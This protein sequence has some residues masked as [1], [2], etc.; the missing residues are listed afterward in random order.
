MIDVKNKISFILVI[1]FPYLL[2]AQTTWQSEMVYFDDNDQLVYERDQDQNQIPDFSYAGYKN[3]ETR[4]PDVP[5]VNEI[6]PV[7]GDN[8]A[9][10]QDAL[11][12][13][14]LMPA[15]SN[16]IRGALLLKAGVYEVPGTIKL[17]F[18]GVVLR[19]EGDGDDP[20]NNTI[21]K[22]TGNSPAQRTIIVAGGGGTTKWADGVSG[23]VVN[24]TS[25]TVFVGDRTFEVASAANYNIGDNIIIVHPCTQNWLQSI[26]FGGTYSD[27]TGAEPGVDVPWAVNSHPLVFNRFIKNIDG[28]KITVGAPIFNHLIKNLA[29]SYIY[30]YTRFNIKTQ[31]GIEN[32]RVDIVTAGG[33]DEN[34]AWNA[35]DLYQIEDAWVRDCTM[36]HFGLSGIRTNTA[37]RITVE[38]CQALD[39][40]SAIEGGK[41]YNF[42][43][44][45]ASQQILFKNCHATNGR[46]HYVSNGTSWVSGC[47]FVDCTSSGAYTSSEGH[48]GWSMGLL[49]DNLIELDGPRPGLNARMLGLY[50]RGFY[51]TS[52]GWSTAHSVAWACDM[53]DG[54]LI[55]QQPPTAQNYAI[56]CLGKNITGQRPPA[57]FPD[58]S[59][60]IEGSNL[61]GL[62]P[63]S[64]YLAQLEDRLGP[65][66]S[67]EP[68]WIA[69]IPQSMI[70]HQ[71]YPNPFNPVTKISWQLA[72][73]SQ[74]ELSIYNVLGEKMAT[75]VD[76]YQPAGFYQLGWDAGNFASGIYYYKLSTGLGLVQTRKMLFVK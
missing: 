2:Q 38:N 24:I 15:D 10:I 19:G 34:H 57:P 58:E 72:V 14:G 45:T 29:Q 3:G 74:V 65:A 68:G 67:V 76:E 30:K 6:E 61:P 71:N 50:N 28:N 63:R 37:T 64:L 46:H 8:T 60:Y 43:V 33:G 31:I 32:L 51:G 70:L 66:V 54:D 5:T 20:A 11:E 13:I 9:H 18:D 53:N 1:L 25:D 39:P 36:L 7:E 69:D 26:D 55:I 56:G 21:I 42:Q 47:V 16:G 35:I 4:I 59:G 73:G 75:L 52:H 23:S 40:V 17:R 41:R 22:G 12:Q 49:Y 62:E 27:S 48:R 44:Y